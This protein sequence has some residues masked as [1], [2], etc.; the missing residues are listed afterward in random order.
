MPGFRPR[1]PDRRPLIFY[2]YMG[3]VAFTTNFPLAQAEA[4]ALDRLAQAVTP[5]VAA[6]ITEA[7]RL[8]IVDD[9]GPIVAIGYDPELARPW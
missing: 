5:H 1:Q 2:P 9:S 8:L 4:H 3:W 6:A 7:H